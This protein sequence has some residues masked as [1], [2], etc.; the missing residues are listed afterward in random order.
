MTCTHSRSGRR[1]M[2]GHWLKWATL[3]H[4]S[5]VP[6]GHGVTAA[7]GAVVVTGGASVAAAT[8]PGARPS[9]AATGLGSAMVSDGFLALADGRRRLIRGSVVVEAVFGVVR[10]VV[11]SVVP[12]SSFV[13]GGSSSRSHTADCE[14]R[15]DFP[16]K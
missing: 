9:V 14:S 7:A 2:P 16:V 6:G 1:T 11:V 3:A 15:F 5:R 4:T 10:C 12:A 13:L 8:A